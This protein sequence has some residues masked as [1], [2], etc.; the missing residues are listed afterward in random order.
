MRGGIGV[1]F[2]RLLMKAMDELSGDELSSNRTPMALKRNTHKKTWFSHN[3]Q[4]EFYYRYTQWFSFQ[5]GIGLNN[6]GGTIHSLDSMKVSPGMPGP[7]PPINNNI[8]PKAFIFYHR[9]WESR[10][11]ITKGQITDFSSMVHTV[12]GHQQHLADIL[13]TM[14]TEYLHKAQTEVRAAGV[15]KLRVEFWWAADGRP[16]SNIICWRCFTWAPVDCVPTTLARGHTFI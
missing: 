5:R 15:G 16:T 11:S 1:E 13:V 14:T 7:V 6:Q 12:K 10:A 2:R 4:Y 8:F 3:L 9:P